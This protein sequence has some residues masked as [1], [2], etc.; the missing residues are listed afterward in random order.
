MMVRGC[1]TRISIGIEIR[2]PII[3]LLPDPMAKTVWVSMSIHGMPGACACVVLGDR[4]L[5]DIWWWDGIF[6]AAVR[7][8]GHGHGVASVRTQRLHSSWSRS[9]SR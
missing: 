7:E 2:L 6:W 9:R 4:G 8:G 3:Q 1:T 5:C